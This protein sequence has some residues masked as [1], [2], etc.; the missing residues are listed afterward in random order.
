MSVRIF[1]DD[2]SIIVEGDVEHEF[3]LQGDTD[4]IAFSDGTLIKVD[5]NDTDDTYKL[6]IVAGNSDYSQEGISDLDNE[7]ILTIDASI[8]W[9]VFGELGRE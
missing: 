5:F 3:T 8:D 4:Y 7:G 2:A 9:V 6:S 1:V